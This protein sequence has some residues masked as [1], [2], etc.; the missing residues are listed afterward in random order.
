MSIKKSQITNRLKRILALVLACITILGTV[1][2]NVI[3]QE[4]INQTVQ[5][6]AVISQEEPEYEPDPD[7]EYFIPSTEPITIM[8][9]GNE[10]IV[11]AQ[12][13]ARIIPTKAA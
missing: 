13:P 7:F 3:A 10:V 5:Q 12:T 8:F 11:D 9:E 4:P 2:M 1:P 6:A